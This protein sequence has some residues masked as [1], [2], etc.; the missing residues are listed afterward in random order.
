VER[1]RE[2]HLC[3]SPGDGVDGEQRGH[4]E[5][6]LISERYAYSAARSNFDGEEGTSS[7]RMRSVDSGDAA[8]TE[9]TFGWWDMFVAPED[10]PRADGGFANNERSILVGYLSDRRL[11]LPLKCTGLDPEGMARRSVPPSNMS[12]LG[13][14]RHLTDVERHWFRR[15]LE[16]QDAPPLYRDADGNDTDFD[17]A[18]ADPDVVHAAWE[19]WRSEIANAED[20]IRRTDDLGRLGTGE[21]VA[22]REVLVHMI[23]EYARHLGHADLLRERIDGRVGQ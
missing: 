11:T 20:V 5:G 18:I 1:E 13:L 3:S 14:V 4:G 7:A 22:T 10:D 2:R 8:P 6:H 23:E 17:G 21:A 12:L 9:R 15:V 16:G 19:A